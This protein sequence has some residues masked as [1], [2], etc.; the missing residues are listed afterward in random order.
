MNWLKSLAIAISTFSAIPMP[1]LSWD[2]KATKQSVV[3]LPVVGLIISAISWIW[4]WFSRR[5]GLTGVLYASGATVLP[6]LLSG[7]IHLDGFLD[8]I[9]ALSSHQPKE[10]K[11][12][13]LKDPHIGAFGFIYGGI[14]YLIMFGLYHALFPSSAL[15]AVFASFI[16]SRSLA[17]LSTMSLPHARKSGML[18]AMSTASGTSQSRASLVVVVLIFFALLL[19]YE[20]VAGVSLLVMSLLT[21]W[22]YRHQ[23]VKQFG[24]ATGDTTGYFISL[25]ELTC[26][27]GIWFGTLL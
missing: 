14:Y 19:Y 17:A 25:C 16:L 21:Y 24:G 7:G 4:L 26:L 3:W 2:E 27:L 10:R 8:T 23:T 1:Q 6:I 11:L 5:Y 12:E 18:H 13:I 9:D 22:F 20:T 15:L